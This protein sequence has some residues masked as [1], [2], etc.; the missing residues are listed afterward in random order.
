MLLQFSLLPLSSLGFLGIKSQ[1]AGIAI[2][3]GWTIWLYTFV[4]TLMRQYISTWE[5]KC[6]AV[7]TVHV[8]MYIRVSLVLILL[9]L[10]T[11]LGFFDG[12][13]RAQLVNLELN[14][15]FHFF[16]FNFKDFFR[17]SGISLCQYRRAG[18]YYI[19]ILFVHLVVHYFH[20]F[21]TLCTRL[22]SSMSSPTCSAPRPSEPL[23]FFLPYVHL[24]R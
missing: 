23:A 1:D 7:Y 11:F 17:F 24:W 3:F 5:A 19:S 14:A 12:L 21:H 13:L 4:P 15:L 18:H 16:T 10:F 20:L 2:L 22:R 9:L 6:S 8:G